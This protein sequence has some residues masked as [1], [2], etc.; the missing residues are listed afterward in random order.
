MDELLSKTGLEGLAF[1]LLHE[2]A[3]S[4]KK[5]IRHNL[6]ESYRYGDLRR[7][8]FFF[9]NQYTGFDALFLDYYTNTRF[10]LE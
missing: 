1:A 10:T 7:Q 4:M 2:L 9:N 3:H 5:H 6:R 8:L